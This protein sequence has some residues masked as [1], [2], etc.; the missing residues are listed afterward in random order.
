[1][2]LT[3][4]YDAISN[5]PK[6]L[7]TLIL[8]ILIYCCKLQWKTHCF[9]SFSV[10]CLLTQANALCC[11]AASSVLLCSAQLAGKLSKRWRNAHARRR[12]LHLPRDVLEQS[13]INMLSR[14]KL[15]TLTC[16]IRN[17]V[18][19]IHAFLSARFQDVW[20]LNAV[21]IFLRCFRPTLPCDGQTGTSLTIPVDSPAYLGSF[22]IPWEHL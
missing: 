13:E 5:F 22:I 6:L 14:K 11:S 1:M 16:R 4:R 8:Q 7:P 9:I 18:A 3:V 17:H 2:L 21:L 12:V 15:A 20:Q 19:S 10:A